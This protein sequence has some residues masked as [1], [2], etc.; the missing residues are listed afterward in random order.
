MC[1]SHC[2]SKDFDH[3]KFLKILYI[4]SWYFYVK[5]RVYLDENIFLIYSD[6]Q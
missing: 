5:K 2:I 4:Q 1:E 6:K 3:Y